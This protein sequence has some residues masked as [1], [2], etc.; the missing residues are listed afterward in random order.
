[1]LLCSAVVASSV[2]TSHGYAQHALVQA[3]L[4]LLAAALADPLNARF[5]L[6][7]ETSIPVRVSPVRVLLCQL[8][9]VCG[10]LHW[11][12][13]P[14]YGAGCVRAHMEAGERQHV[15]GSVER[16]PTQRCAITPA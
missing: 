5:V 3:E 8:A 12:S 10:R 13:R 1:G 15:A 16:H 14:V 2:N 9:R 4:V 11:G 6:L 7:S